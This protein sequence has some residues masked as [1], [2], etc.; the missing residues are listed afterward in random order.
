MARLP[1][2]TS[3]GAT[4]VRHDRKPTPE[5]EQHFVSLCA[6]LE[7]ARLRHY[8]ESTGWKL[9]GPHRHVAVMYRCGIEGLTQHELLFAP[10]SDAPDY[11]ECVADSLTK[12]GEVTGFPASD[13]RRVVRDTQLPEARG[14]R[15]SSIGVHS[16]DRFTS[17]V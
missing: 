12:L 1:I 5:H 11:G 14:G 17:Y 8:I 2:M 6:E 10:R 3:T 16:Y 4:R 13:M 7:P 9:E 15:R